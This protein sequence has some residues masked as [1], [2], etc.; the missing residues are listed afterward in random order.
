MTLL[1]GVLLAGCLLQS[2]R[3][4]QVTPSPNGGAF[5]EV[6]FY[7]TDT[8]GSG[9]IEEIDVS[10]MAINLDVTV[11]AKVGSGKLR[12]ELLEGNDDLVALDVEATGE[13]TSSFKSI[14]LNDVGNLR[15][16]VWATNA[17]DGT[18]S[19]S[20][21]PPPTPTPTPTPTP[22]PTLTPTPTATTTPTVTPVEVT[23]TP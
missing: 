12:I 9:V 4:E 1:G 18:Y 17:R 5:H 6:T 22:E 16:R 13:G 14:R 3:Q 20:Y 7:S 23:P 19:I 21:A 11:R 8:N 2:A 15:Y 10:T